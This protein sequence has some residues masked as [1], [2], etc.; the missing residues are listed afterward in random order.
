M[1][2]TY[3]LTWVFLS[4]LHWASINLMQNALRTPS[5]LLLA[6]FPRVC[7]SLGPAPQMAPTCCQL[8]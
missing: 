1:W 2:S 4:L 3:S 8:Y 7:A 5:L 6:Y